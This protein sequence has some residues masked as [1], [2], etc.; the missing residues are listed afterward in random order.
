MQLLRLPAPMEV[1][2]LTGDDDGDAMQEDITDL[3]ADADS[4]EDVAMDDVDVEDTAAS[5][6]PGEGAGVM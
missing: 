6:L 4:M 3:T 5:M 1:V 2:D